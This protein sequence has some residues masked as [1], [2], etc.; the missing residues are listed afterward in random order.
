[1]N[2]GKIDNYFDVIECYFSI[3]E[4]RPLQA[5]IRFANGRPVPWNMPTIVCSETR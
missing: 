5:N 3:V 2:E 1:M 4:L